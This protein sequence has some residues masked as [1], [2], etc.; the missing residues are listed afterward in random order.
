MKKE[1][2]V[3]LCLIF[4]TISFSVPITYANQ[5]RVI[6]YDYDEVSLVTDYDCRDSPQSN[7]IE[8]EMQADTW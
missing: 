1:I 5:N 3:V 8:D 7:S 6:F 4:S 2:L